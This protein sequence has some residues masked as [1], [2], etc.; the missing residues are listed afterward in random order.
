MC[1]R[2][3]LAAA[4]GALTIAAPA[5]FLGRAGFFPREAGPLCIV[6]LAG[7]T[8][9]FADSLLGATLQ[10]G[11]RFLGLRVLNLRSAPKVFPEALSATTR[12][13]YVLP[14]FSRLTSAATRLPTRPAPAFRTRVRRV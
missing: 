12:K 6:F 13:W 10:A 5:R 2:D 14:G 3:G 7:L 1:I 11:Y 9:A 4:A 8:G